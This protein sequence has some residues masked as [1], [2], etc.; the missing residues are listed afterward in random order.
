MLE[1]DVERV[2]GESVAH[3]LGRQPG[4]GAVAGLI[5]RGDRGH[6]EIEALLG[7]TGGMGIVVETL[8][9]AR[10]LPPMEKVCVVAQTTQSEE[11]F[12]AISEKLKEKAKESLIFNTI[13]EST[14]KRQA[15]IKELANK[16]DLLIIIGGKDSGN[17]RR[18]AE[19]AESTGTPSIHIESEEEL[20]AKD[21]NGRRV[22][23]VSA[24]ASTPSWVIGKVIDKIRQLGGSGDV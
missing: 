15:E 13:C 12:L 4:Q 21:F 14:N 18:L 17:T 11:K 24:G 10:M 9:E 8:E 2:G 1:R 22:I 6:A 3:Q 23:G 19:I 5:R 16:T 7:Y 20:D